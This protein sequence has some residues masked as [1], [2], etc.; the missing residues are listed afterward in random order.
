[1]GF[2]LDY[3]LEKVAQVHSNANYAM[4]FI[5]NSNERHYLEIAE[6]KHI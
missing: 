2:A 4:L 3:I 6:I 5:S 1:M